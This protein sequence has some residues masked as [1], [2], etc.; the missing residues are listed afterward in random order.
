MILAIFFQI[1]TKIITMILKGG[2]LNRR[3]AAALVDGRVRL[4]TKV[5]LCQYFEKLVFLSFYF[6]SLHARVTKQVVLCQYFEKFNHIVIAVSD[7]IQNTALFSTFLRPSVR[8]LS[9]A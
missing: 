2:H 1:I 4:S 6:M 8:P 7:S 3:A 9:Q 5:V